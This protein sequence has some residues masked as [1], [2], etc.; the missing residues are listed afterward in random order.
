MQRWSWLELPRFARFLTENRPD[1]IL[2]LYLGHMYFNQPM[3]TFAPSVAHSRLPGVRFVTQFENV[4]GTNANECSVLT[5]G[6]RRLA[7][8]WVGPADVD[9]EFGTLVR[10]SDHIVVLSDSFITRLRESW[11]AV[12]GKTSIIPPPPLIHLAPG[13][14]GAA[15]LSQRQR[16]GVEEGDFLI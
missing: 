7:K 6:V 13:D 10:D 16:L 1:A 14:G 3:I 9:Y 11:A 4:Y 5:R 12:D 8:S 15:R 2:L